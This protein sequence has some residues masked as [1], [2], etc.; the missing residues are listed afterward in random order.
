LFKSTPMMPDQAHSRIETLRRVLQEHNHNYY[1][2]ASP[3]I[4]DFEYDLL[5]KELQSLEADFP[6]FDNENSPSR[7]VG[8]DLNREF[9]SYPHRYPMLSL[10]NTY[11]REELAEFDL[12][13]RK[14]ADAEVKYFCELKYDGVAVALSYRNGELFRALTRGDGSRGD[15]VTHNIRTIRSIPLKLTGTHIPG[16][17][18]IRGEV[19]LPT[20]GFREM[21]R[22]RESAGELPFANPRNAASGTLKMQNSSL[23][24]LRPLDCLCYYIPGEQ[25]LF[26]THSE[27]LERARSWGFK[28]PEYGQLTASMDEVFAYIDKW[29]TERTKLPFD[30]DGVVIKVDSIGLQQQLGFTAK[31][32]RWAISYKF[33]AEQAIS[34]LTSIDFQVGRTGAVTPV[35]NLEP[36][37][38]AGTTVKRASLHNAD[39]IRLLDIREGDHV[40][41]EKGGEIIP[42][43]VGVDREKRQTGS[44]P[45]QFIR[46]CPE[47]G[48]PLVR[49]EDEAAHYCPNISGCPTQIKGRIEHFISRR[50][51]DI[52]AAEATIELLYRKGWVKDVA[53]LYSLEVSAVQSL[54]RFGEKSAKNLVESIQLSR[55][56]PF[57]RVLYALGIRY[58][59]ETVARKLAEAFL[60][61]EKL[62]KASQEELEQVDEIG[63]R[64][65]QSLRGYFQDER[66]LQVIE[67]LRAAGLQ[68]E[69]EAPVPTG[70]KLLSGKTFVISGVFEHHSREALKSM[71]EQHG[72]KNSSSIS[73]RTHFVLAGE[74]MGP[75]KYEKAQKLGVPIISEEDF[76]EMLSG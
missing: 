1:V 49:K 60:S 25:Q 36:V 72:G 55:Q 28:V 65:A 30:I 39:Q 12:R 26:Q 53:D 68:L 14:L 57:P 8:S 24:A 21:N 13:V 5:L 70:S 59:G 29:E 63:E 22:K 54:E 56:V 46:E 58:V 18:E 27:G 6:E 50:A 23:V 61:L 38:L 32:P 69:M 11:N 40:Y 7:R 20:E 3:S 4:S 31:T 71:I 76:M 64:I 51:M 75:S 43:I 10:G 37:Q 33:R 45:F 47:C 44:V 35:A 73:A 66:N 19:I 2:K 34:R 17:F 52:N 9:T 74:N 15:D 62:M 42:K 41:V 67:R 48:T 16:E